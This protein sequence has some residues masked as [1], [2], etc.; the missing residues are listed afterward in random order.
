MEG[1]GTGV[2]SITMSHLPGATKKNPIKLF[3]YLYMCLFTT[4][5]ANYEVSTSKNANKTKT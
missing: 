5:N 2:I 3:V 1:N 4:P